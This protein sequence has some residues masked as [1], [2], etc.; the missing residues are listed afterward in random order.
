MDTN[1][2]LSITVGV[3]ALFTVLVTAFVLLQPSAEDLLVQA[4]EA[5]Q[6]LTA[7]HAVVN[8]NLNA[9]RKTP[10]QPSISGLK[11]IRS[12][13]SAHSALKSLRSAKRRSKARSLLSMGIPSRSIIRLK[14]KRSSPAYR[15]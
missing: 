11:P 13:R 10:A 9:I 8:V 6:D 1:R 5:P 4:L 12:T 14:T 7:A 3:T 2:N 15:M